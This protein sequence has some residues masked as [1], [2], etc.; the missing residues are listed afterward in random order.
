M[1]SDKYLAN[2]GNDK[3]TVEKVQPATTMNTENYVKVSTACWL[4]LIP[5][6]KI[7]QLL[8]MLLFGEFTV[9]SSCD[10]SSENTFPQGMQG[11]A[12]H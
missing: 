1:I 10:C 3:I 2:I 12:T 9:I 11:L 7:A 4:P 5:C 6:L 8:L